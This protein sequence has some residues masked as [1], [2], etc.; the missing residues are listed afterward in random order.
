MKQL[1]GRLR[2]SSKWT[3]HKAE[4]VVRYIE[5][6]SPM[7]WDRPRTDVV[8]VRNGLLNVNTRTL[9]EH[10]PD[11]L[12]PVQLPVD[13]DP[14]AQCPAWDKFIR[15]V[16]A[17]DSEAIG[18]E[19]P[20]WLMTPDTSIQKAVLLMGDGANGKSTYLRAVLAFLGRRH[21]SAI[22]LHRLEKDLTTRIWDAGRYE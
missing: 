4:E 14:H 2:L 17:S 8:N 15:Q 19:I 11:H 21:V 13:F 20:A 10:S 12:S 16:L 9:S 3:S 1:L 18:W 22:S 6:D 5:V 7:L